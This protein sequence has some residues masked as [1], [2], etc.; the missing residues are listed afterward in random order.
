MKCRP[1]KSHRHA[2]GFVS[3][4]ENVLSIDDVKALGVKYMMQYPNAYYDRWRSVA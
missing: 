3:T 2:S 4:G 1:G